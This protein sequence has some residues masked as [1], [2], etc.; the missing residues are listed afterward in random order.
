MI[1]PD[2]RKTLRTGVLAAGILTLGALTFKTLQS[3]TPLQAAPTMKPSENLI[4]A[5]EFPANAD[6]LNT[7][8]PLSIRGLKGKIVLL[9]FWTYAC[10]NCMQILPDLKKL[11]RKYPNELVIVGVHSAK[12]DNEGE[13]QNIRNA[14]LRY[15]IEHPVL[16]DK[17]MRVWEEYAVKGWP[18]LTLIDPNGRIVRQ[19][20]GEGQYEALDA[21]IGKLVT[22]FK[23]RGEL[24]SSPMEFAL[25]AAQ[26]QKTPLSFPGKVLADGK[27]NRLFTADSNHNR[28]IISDLNGNVQAV[29]GSGV[30]GLADG[31]FQTATFHNPQGMTLSEDGITLYVADTDNHTIRALD[32][33]TKKV[34]TIAGTGKQ[35]AWRSAGGIGTKAALASPWDVLRIGS[36]LYV[37]MA[38]SHQVWAMDLNSKKIEPFAGTGAEARLDGK[39]RGA[40][41][42]QPSGLATDGKS[43]FFAD[44][45]S[46]S[47][48]EVDLVIR[49][50]HGLEVRTLV[51]GDPNPRNLFAF[52]D[53]DGKSFAAKLQHPLGVAYSENMVY[54]ADTYNHKIKVLDTQSGQIST[55]ALNTKFSEP[56]GLNVAGNQLFIADTNDQK[57]RVV[58]LKTKVVSD[59]EFKNLPAPLPAEPQRVASADAAGVLA[60]TKV[61][62]APNSKGEVIFDVKLPSGFHV[63][64][65]APQKFDA[66]IEGKG[67][68]LAQTKI[69]NKEFS[70]PLRVKFSSLKAG[71]SGVFVVSA[72]INY[73]DDDA[74]VCKFKS[75]QVKAPFE[76][77]DGGTANFLVSSKINDDGSASTLPMSGDNLT[78]AKIKMSKIVKTDEEWKAELTPEQYEVMR[79][80]GTERAFT[81]AL[82]KNHDDGVYKCAACGEELFASDTKFDSGT[83][84]PSFYQPINDT[85]VEEETDVTYGMRR[86]EVLCA[87]C[88]AHLGH[89]FDDGPK[90]TGLRYCINSAS[91]EFE[92]KKQN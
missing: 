84:W 46:S 19:E 65:E 6:W 11:E 89:V 22:E 55:L 80:K 60:P 74:T 51:G 57:I 48:R 63:N 66:R 62:L 10:I 81:G 70:L 4:R 71:T 18:T 52:G 39:A 88:E 32:L 64:K 90:P 16:N 75:F 37:A 61:T 12:F 7:D 26:V 29:A 3:Q 86:T 13:T 42:A 45:E 30:Q 5:P 15:K 72:S 69:R 2:F 59:V 36:T 1:R 82:L 56:G 47:I 28:V 83:G 17:T 21:A 53:K 73:C 54:V 35:A 58:D 79:R 27:S 49:G 85:N 91:L 41:L 43:L 50:I 38:G 23:A 40:A 78:G 76:V 34:V 8:K 87:R 14:I 25:E 77:K 31:G 20:S 67:I 68:T 9:D 24:K 92:E 44:S 33:K